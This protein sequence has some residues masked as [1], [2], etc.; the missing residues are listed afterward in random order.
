M[1]RSKRQEKT[2][3]KPL[4]KGRD[5]HRWKGDVDI[6]EIEET[7]D[8]RIQAKNRSSKQ[9]PTEEDNQDDY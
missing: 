2:S 1:S 9:K 7:D 5:K 4:H 6:D 3:F 8:V